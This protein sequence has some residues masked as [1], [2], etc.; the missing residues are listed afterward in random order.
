ML[1]FGE[2]GT[3]LLRSHKMTKILTPFPHCS[4][5]FDFG[6]P[7]CPV[8]VQNFTPIPLPPL[9]LLPHPYQNNS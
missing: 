3:Q 5:L 8:N 6:N 4:H 7:S 2:G 1:R 9:L